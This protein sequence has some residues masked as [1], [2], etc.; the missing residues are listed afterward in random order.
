MKD[1]KGF[2]ALYTAAYHGNREVVELL[3]R[4]GADVNMQT[5]QKNTALMA[6]SRQGNESVVKLLLKHGALINLRNHN[7]QTALD[8]VRDHL[9]LPEALLAASQV[10]TESTIAMI[11]RLARNYHATH[12]YS[13]SDQFA[14]VAMSC[15]LWNQIQT[16]G[17][18]AG[19]MAGNVERNIRREHWIEYVKEIN[20]AWVLAEVAPGRWVPVESTDGSIIRPENKNH[21]LYFSGEFFINPRELSR[22]E[23]VRRN[24]G[25]V[26]QEAMTMR[27]ILPK[28]REHR[29]YDWTLHAAGFADLRTHDCINHLKEI[30]EALQKNDRRGV[31][32]STQ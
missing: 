28:I 9:K 16:Q 23:E 14:C 10:A 2:P 27:A 4:A 7:G 22:F 12:T 6:A 32:W 30:Y 29:S 24:I 18:R 17:I 8:F 25:K 26:C 20:H 3:L 21:S 31:P 5:P 15:D 11:E 19:L 13:L 1:D